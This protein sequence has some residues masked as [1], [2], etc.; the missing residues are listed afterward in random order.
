MYILFWSYVIVAVE[1]IRSSLLTVLLRSVMLCW[2]EADLP[3]Y[4][5]LTLT[6]DYWL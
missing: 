1:S 6:G 2:F 4:Q 5:V 3:I